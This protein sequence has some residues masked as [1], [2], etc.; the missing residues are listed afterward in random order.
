MLPILADDVRSKGKSLQMF[1]SSSQAFVTEH[2]KDKQKEVSQSELSFLNNLLEKFPLENSECFEELL[3][4][5]SVDNM[6]TDINQFI[7]QLL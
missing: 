4:Q 2:L 7:R 6:Q 5:R 1:D 3:V